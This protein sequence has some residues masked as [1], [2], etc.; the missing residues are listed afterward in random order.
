MKWTERIRN[1]AVLERVDEERIILKL[2]NEGCTGRNVEHIPRKPKR[3]KLSVKEE[4]AIVRQVK[5]NPMASATKLRSSLDVTT[6]GENA[7]IVRP[8]GIC[9]LLVLVWMPSFE[10]PY[11]T[12]ECQSITRMTVSWR[13]RSGCEIHWHLGLTGASLDVLIPAS[14]SNEGRSEYRRLVENAQVVRPVGIWDLLVL[15]WMSSFQPPYQT[16]EGQSIRRTTVSWRERSGS[17]TRWHLGL[18]GASLDVLI[19]ASLS[20]EGSL[21]TKRGKV[22]VLGGRR[23]VGENAQ[24]VRPVSIWNLLVLVWIPHSSLPTKR[25]K[26][27]VLGGRRLVG[28][29]AQVVRPVSIWNLLVLVWIPHSSLPTKR[30]KVRVLGG[31]R[32]VGENAQVVRW[33]VA[34]P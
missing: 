19:P 33:P 24:I 27:R 3:M 10:P 11:Q 26:V 21:S 12:R 6:V 23:L 20:N 17:E 18:T 25:G 22:R 13:E 14:L 31:R 7:Q 28:E 32:L 9:D 1:E 4:R 8:V 29:N 5:S 16:R 30:G 34:R 2:P 15:V